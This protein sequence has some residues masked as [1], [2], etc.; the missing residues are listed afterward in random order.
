MGDTTYIIQASVRRSIFR[1]GGIR[2]IHDF[3]PEH[4][5]TLSIERL[6]EEVSKIVIGSH[7]W[8]NQLA[9]LNH[10]S[11]VKPSAIN[12]FGTRMVFR[13]VGQIAGTF[14]VTMQFHRRAV[15]QAE[16]LSETL[17]INSLFRS[18]G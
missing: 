9:I 8:Y 1:T 18:F 11:H 4:E 12:V 15:S 10:F 16:L 14:V 6:R 3:I 5:E 17:E 13:V 2:N 7:I